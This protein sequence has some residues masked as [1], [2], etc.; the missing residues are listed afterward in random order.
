MVADSSSAL[1]PGR[2]SVAGSTNAKTAISSAPA[3]RNAGQ[4]MMATRR[5]SCFMV[6]APAQGRGVAAWLRP[7]TAGISEALAA[8][9]AESTGSG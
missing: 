4:A 3:P 7:W 8:G 2:L 1:P 6:Q 9:G 5:A